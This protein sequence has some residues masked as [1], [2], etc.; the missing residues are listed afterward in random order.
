MNLLKSAIGITFSLFLCISIS[1]AKSSVS[2]DSLSGVVEIQRAGNV[3]WEYASKSSKLFHNDLARIPDTGMAVLKWPDGTRS[4]LHKKSQILVT[5]L[6]KKNSSDIVSNVT[7]M[8]GT[9]FFIVKKLLPKDRTEEM[10][11]Y[12]PIYSRYVISCRC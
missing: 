1:Y 2:F 8:F 9:A 3:K 5:L 11:I 6:Q 4:F 10:K 12:T 7:I